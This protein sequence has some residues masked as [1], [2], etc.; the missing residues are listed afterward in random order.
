MTLNDNDYLAWRVFMKVKSLVLAAVASLCCRGYGGSVVIEEEIPAFREGVDAYN[1]VGGGG[2][3]EGG[4]FAVSVTNR[5][6]FYMDYSRFPG[7]KPFSGVREVVLETEYDGL[8]GARAELVLTEFPGGGR[9]QFF[10]PLA[11]KTHFKTDLDPAEKYQLRALGVQG[12]RHGGG[13][14]KKIGRAHV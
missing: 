5:S 10:A 2:A 11:G 9:R 8:E 12:V 1:V 4:A 3:W 13:E 14:W 6:S 7:M